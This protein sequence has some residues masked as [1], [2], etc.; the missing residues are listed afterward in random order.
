MQLNPSKS[1]FGP[2][3]WMGANFVWL[4]HNCRTKMHLV[5]LKMQYNWTKMHFFVLKMHFVGLNYILSEKVKVQ[6]FSA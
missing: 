5:E 1:I 4:I 6:T 3:K 2:K